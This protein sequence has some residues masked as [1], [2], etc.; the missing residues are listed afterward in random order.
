MFYGTISV[1][2]FF[3][4]LHVYCCC[5]WGWGVCLWVFEDNLQELVFSN[6]VVLDPHQIFMLGSRHHYTNEPS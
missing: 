5:C 1:Y 4:K 3:K 2:F 6:Y